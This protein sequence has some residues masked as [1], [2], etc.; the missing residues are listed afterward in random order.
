M[1]DGW[2]TTW[3]SFDAVEP[4]RKDL[5]DNLA[6]WLEWRRFTSWNFARYFRETGDMLRKILP[7]AKVSDNFYITPGLDGWDLFELAKQTDYMAMDIYA[8][9]R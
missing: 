3:A 1:N 5:A 4:P 8:I 9:G 6:N 2:K 7:N